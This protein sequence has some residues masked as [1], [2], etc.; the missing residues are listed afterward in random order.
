MK[1]YNTNVGAA[2]TQLSGMQKQL[3]AIARV[4]L[5]DPKVLILDEP[6]STLD[7]ESEKIV[8]ETLN[9][10]REGGTT[11]ITAHRLSTIYDANCIAV[12]KEGKVVGTQLSGIQKQLV[13][14]A[15]VLLRDP[16]VLILDEP[17]SSLDTGPTWVL[18]GV[19]RAPWSPSLRG[20]ITHRMGA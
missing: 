11:I 13:A 15:R 14:I 20:F 18:V 10:A 17:T 7:M 3:V 16:K 19:A 2:G 12:I 8:Q 9:R 4:L 6:T 5:R 1:G